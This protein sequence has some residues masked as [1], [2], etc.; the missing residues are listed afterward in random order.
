MLISD[1]LI[2]VIAV[3]G[4]FLLLR[5]LSE[6]RCSRFG[7]AGKHCVVTGGSMG[8]GKAVAKV[9]VCLCAHVLCEAQAQRLLCFCCCAGR[10]M[11][12][13]ASVSART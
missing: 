8:I 1:W 5:L 12:R 11:R 13:N 4:S 6:L 7:V 2:A 9:P 10:K 3:I